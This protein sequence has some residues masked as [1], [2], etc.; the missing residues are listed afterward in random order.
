MVLTPNLAQKMQEMGIFAYT[1]QTLP[2]GSIEIIAD[3]G[4]AQ[5]SVRS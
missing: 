3:P 1:V 2:D 4:P 5:R